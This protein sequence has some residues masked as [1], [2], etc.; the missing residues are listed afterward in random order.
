MRQ[1]IEHAVVERPGGGTLTRAYVGL[2][3]MR[4]PVKVAEALSAD[5]QA[6][7]DEHDNNINN[8][9]GIRHGNGNRNRIG[10]RVGFTCLQFP[11]DLQRA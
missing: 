10:T 7:S 9:L 5:I 2:E 1:L 3:Q 8:I 11:S 4:A 6:R